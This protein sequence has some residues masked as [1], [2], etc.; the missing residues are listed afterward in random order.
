MNSM[1][2]FLNRTVPRASR[3]I[4]AAAFLSAALIFA[5]CETTSSRT[6]AE[7]TDVRPVTKGMSAAEV[8]EILGEPLRVESIEQAG[9]AA[10][11]W[12]YEKEVVLSST[13]ESDGEQERVYNDY[14]TGKLV[15]VREPIWRNETVKG[16]LVAEL[17]MVEGKVAALKERKEAVDYDVSH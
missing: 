5:G 12:L 9:V 8:I 17:L 11:I 7:A 6:V 14:A 15:T 1:S 16:K 3:A 10:E 2:S 4:L 13:I